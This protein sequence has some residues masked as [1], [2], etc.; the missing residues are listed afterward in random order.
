MKWS[1]EVKKKALNALAKI[2]LTDRVKIAQFLE[3][4][5]ANIDNPRQCGKSLEGKF[6]GLWRY[7]V[8]NYRIICHIKDNELLIIAVEIGHRSKVYKQ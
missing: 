3:Q 7:R 4:T 5:L 8:G 6:K 2:N 1:I